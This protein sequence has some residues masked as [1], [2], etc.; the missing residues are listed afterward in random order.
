MTY[1][2]LPVGKVTKRSMQQPRDVIYLK[3]MEQLNAYN[4]RRK[5]NLN[6]DEFLTLIGKDVNDLEKE[7]KNFNRFEYYKQ[8]AYYKNNKPMQIKRCSTKQELLTV[9]HYE[10]QI[11]QLKL[12]LDSANKINESILSELREE[13]FKRIDKEQELNKIKNK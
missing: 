6:L 13:R 1:K 4:L 3:Y 8:N 7:I 12:K 5:T 10:N 11:K 2:K 9:E